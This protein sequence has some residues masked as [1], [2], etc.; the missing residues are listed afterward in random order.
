MSSTVVCG[1]TVTD[2]P[3]M[4]VTLPDGALVAPSPESPL[5]PSGSPSGLSVPP[6]GV[7][8]VSGASVMGPDDGVTSVLPVGAASVGA[9]EVGIG[10]GDGVGARIGLCD[11]KG[12]GLSVGAGV[13]AGVGA[14]VGAGVGVEL[15]PDVG[16]DVGSWVGARVGIDVEGDDVGMLV[17]VTVV[18]AVEV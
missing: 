15:G 14:R 7:V 8:T 2:D 5:L 3:S 9:A 18:V 6:S 17:L 10:V 13:G 16:A 1:V 12:D 11:G 4:V